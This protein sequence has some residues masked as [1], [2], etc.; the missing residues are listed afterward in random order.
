MGNK[1]S[2]EGKEHAPTPSMLFF[3]ITGGTTAETS[4]V[5]FHRDYIRVEQSSNGLFQNAWQSG[6]LI[7]NKNQAKV[8]STGYRISIVGKK[9]G[10]RGGGR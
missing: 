5:P 10:S 2:I 9:L 7:C 6:W 3:R 8:S 1:K 4:K